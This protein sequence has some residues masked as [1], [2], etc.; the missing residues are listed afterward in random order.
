MLIGKLARHA[1]C[2]AGT[3]RYYER[4]GLLQKPYRASS[5]YRK[6]TDAHLVQLNFVLRCRA[7]GMTLAEI[8]ALQGFQANPGAPCAGINELIDRQIDRIQQQLKVLHVLEKQ[9]ADLR[10][11]CDANMPA[12]ECGIMK[13]LSSAAENDAADKKIKPKPE[14]STGPIKPAP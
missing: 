2:D 4:E 9:L 3:I 14:A 10:C 13:A 12:G 8:K 1:G 7:L 5:G 11:R 6:Y